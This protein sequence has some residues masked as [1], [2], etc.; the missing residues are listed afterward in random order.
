M[1]KRKVRTS[2]RFSLLREA[3][4]RQYMNS[5]N[6]GDDDGGRGRAF[7]L[8][9]QPSGSNHTKAA[10]GFRLDS[11]LFIDSVRYGAECKTGGG[12]VGCLPEDIGRGNS[13]PLV[14]ASGYKA[15]DFRFAD[16]GAAKYT[17]Y[18]YIHRQKRKA[19]KTHPEAWYKE[20]NLVP[21]VVPTELFVRKLIEFGALGW[22][23]NKRNSSAIVIKLP[24]KR[25]QEWVE[26]Y[27]VPFVPDWDYTASDFEDLE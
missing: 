26:N 22:I 20:V 19:D 16:K 18:W 3:A 9:C 15:K 2:T 7:E 23:D 4:V 25:L 13:K 10:S 17:I 5:F 24:N 1:A 8:T 12:R 14:L 27:P 21:I 11:H 6:N